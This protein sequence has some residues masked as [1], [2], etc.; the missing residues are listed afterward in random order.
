MVRDGYRPIMA[1]RT[2]ARPAAKPPTKP[3][4]RKPGGRKPAAKKAPARKPAKRSPRKTAARRSGP[5]PLQ[6][7]GKAVGGSFRLVA[8]G[9]GGVSRAAGSS[10]RDLDPAHRR[11]GLGFVLLICALLAAAGAWWHAGSAGNALAGVVE[12]LFGLGAMVLPV[13]LAV[14]GIRTLRH[15]VS[16]GGRGR[17]LVGWSTLC[18]GALGV[19]HVVRGDL[20]TDHKGGVIGFLL[21]NP[22]QRMLTGFIAGP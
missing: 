14:A 5:S 10:A 1:T 12:G 17:L 13:V 22:L 16:P 11:D 20:P 19:V 8:S 7:A 9:V 6:M 15:P 21:G 4:A 2:P 18:L 3:A